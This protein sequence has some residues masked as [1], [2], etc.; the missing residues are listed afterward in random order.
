[1]SNEQTTQAAT[2]P[3]IPLTPVESSQLAAYGYDAATETLAIEFHG[4]GSKPGSLYHYRH[5]GAS[6]W[7]RFQDAKSKGSHFINNVKPFPGRYPYTRIERTAPADA[8]PAE[9]AQE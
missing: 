8:A 4:Y 7:A 2:P 9:A 6:E 1:M 5:F 3:A